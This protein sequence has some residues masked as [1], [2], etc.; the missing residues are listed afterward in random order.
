MVCVRVCV[1]ASVCVRARMLLGA[2][3]CVCVCVCVCACE[4]TALCVCN[5]RARC[6]YSTSVCRP[7]S[8]PPALNEAEITTCQEATRNSCGVVMVK[9]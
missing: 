9:L 4:Q 2:R 6:V 1:C 7:T 8:M 3:E 5:S